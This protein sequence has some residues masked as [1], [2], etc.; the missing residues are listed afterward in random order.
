[1]KMACEYLPR[2][3]YTSR[4]ISGPGWMENETLSPEPFESGEHWNSNNE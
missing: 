4:R 3:G 2:I 1:M